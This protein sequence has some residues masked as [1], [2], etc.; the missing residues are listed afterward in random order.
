MRLALWFGGETTSGTSFGANFGP[1]WSLK[2]RVIRDLSD[3]FNCFQIFQGQCLTASRF[4]ISRHV[5]V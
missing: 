3:P 1:N 4:S 2:R 5:N